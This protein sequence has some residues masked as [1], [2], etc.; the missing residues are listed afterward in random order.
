[1]SEKENVEG[2]GFVIKDN[3]S[4]QISEENAA[5]LDDQET[6]DQEKQT[7]LSEKKETEPFQIDFSAFIMSLTS[8]AFYHLGD[9]P[10]PS[11]GKTE[12]NL[13]AVQQTIDMLIM[14][15]EK[16]KGNLKEDESKLIE[17]LIYELQVKYVAKTKE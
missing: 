5:F 1:M 9:M 2:E 12:T 8:S 4:S 13:P 17:Q 16:T 6:K 3:R 15:R 14:L 11:T 10:D 7:D